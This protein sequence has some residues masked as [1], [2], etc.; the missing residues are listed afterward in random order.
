M[1]G[2]RRFAN[3]IGALFGLA[4]AFASMRLMSSPLFHVSPVDPLTYGTIAIAIVPIAW[5]ACYL[6]S[7]RAATVDPVQALRSE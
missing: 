4:A 2:S 3:G 7:R 5:M 6:P 1:I